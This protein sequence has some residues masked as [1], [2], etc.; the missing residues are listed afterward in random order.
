MLIG[1]SLGTGVV[2]NYAWRSQWISP[3]VL[4]SPYKSIGRIICDYSFIDSVFNHNMFCSYNK[5]GELRCP[6]R[7]IHGK[8]DKL[9]NIS[10][11]KALYSKLKYPLRSVWKEE[12]D[13]NNITLEKEDLIDLI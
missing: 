5:I 1:R 10:H 2:V 12:C 8:K 3:I 11:G 4:I 9:I 7:I 6:V 13:H